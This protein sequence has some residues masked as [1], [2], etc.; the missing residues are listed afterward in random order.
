MQ[1]HFMTALG[2]PKTQGTP[3]ALHPGSSLHG[4]AKAEGD[5]LGVQWGLPPNLPLNSES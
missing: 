2:P 5:T 4:E 3:S 1:P